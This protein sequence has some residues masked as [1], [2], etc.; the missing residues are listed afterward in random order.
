MPINS[1]DRP[2]ILLTGFG[3]FPSVGANATSVLVPPLAEA[4]QRALGGVRIAA[5]ILPTEWASSLGLLQELIDDLRPTVALHFGV[6]SRATGF[7][8]ETRGRNV[9]CLSEDA[10][11]LLPADCCISVD[12][13]DYLPTTLPASHIVTRLRRRGLPAQI[14]RDAGGYLCNALLYRS[15]ELARQH[16]RPQRTGFVHLPVTLVSERLPEREPRVFNGLDWAGVIEG[17][18]EIISS[19]LGRPGVASST[20]RRRPAGAMI[21]RGN[22]SNGTGLFTA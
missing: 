10:A 4:A 1:T 8:V 5:Y 15:L 11:G 7:E 21:A 12:G 3:P 9:C 6:S 16:G 13:P 14:S 20:L 2:T 17:G 18:V 19:A 22:R